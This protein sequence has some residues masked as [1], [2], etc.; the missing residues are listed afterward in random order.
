MESRK[1]KQQLVLCYNRLLRGYDDDERY[2]LAESQI[3]LLR[4]NSGWTR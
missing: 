1:L 3:I 4:I 2:E